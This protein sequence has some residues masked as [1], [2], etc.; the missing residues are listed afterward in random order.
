[1]KLKQIAFIIMLIP[2]MLFLCMDFSNI[3]LRHILVIF[4]GMTIYGV[5]FYLIFKK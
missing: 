2:I 5:L 4:A 1:M 3:A